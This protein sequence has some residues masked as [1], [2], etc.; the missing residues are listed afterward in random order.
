MRLEQTKPI[1][2]E[3]PDR[4][5]FI[6]IWRTLRTALTCVLSRDKT[7][8]QSPAALFEQGF[9]LL[10]IGQIEAFGEPESRAAA[11]RG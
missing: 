10:Q 11:G 1:Q 9:S 6:A 2:R 5:V 3:L 8:L 4:S 7:L